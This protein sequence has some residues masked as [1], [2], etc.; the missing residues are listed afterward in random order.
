MRPAVTMIFLELVS[1]TRVG[2]S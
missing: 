2:L 1:N